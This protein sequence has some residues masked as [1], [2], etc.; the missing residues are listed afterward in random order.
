MDPPTR[1]WFLVT[2]KHTAT[3]D[4]PPRPGEKG[5]ENFKQAFEKFIESR[6]VLLPIRDQQYWK[7]FDNRTKDGYRKQHILKDAA[8]LKL[9]QQKN[10]KLMPFQVCYTY[11][12]VSLSDLLSIRSTASIG[13]AITGGITSIVFSPMKW[14]W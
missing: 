13:C 6:S 1:L 11:V 10:L 12:R 3:W 9:G 14:A 8:D 5:Y 7:T 2:S 4:A